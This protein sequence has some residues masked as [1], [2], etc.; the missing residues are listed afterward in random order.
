MQTLVE[1]ADALWKGEIGADARGIGLGNIGFRS[2][3]FEQVADG[4]WVLGMTVVVDT[5]QGLIIVDPGIRPGRR[6]RHE[7]VRTISDKPL[8]TAIYT[9]GH[10]DHIWGVDIFA[11]E[12]DARGWARP[13]V[14]AQENMLYRFKRYRKTARW[15]GLINTRQF[16]VSTYAESEV[17]PYP[18][19]YWEPDTT[20]RES[21]D[22][23]VGGVPAQ[24]RH[25][26]GETDDA[27]WVFFPNTGVLCTGDLFVWVVPNAGNPQKVQRYCAEWADALRAM[28]SCQPEILL[29]G[30]GLPIFGRERV[31][32]ALEETAEYLESIEDQT[33]AL[34]NAGATLDEVLQ[35]VRPPAHLVDRPFL[36]PVYDDP[37]FI[38]RNIWRLY[39]GWYDGQAAHLK[40]APERAQA[41]EVARLA[42]SPAALA[43]RAE[44]LAGEGDFRLACHLADWAHLAAPDDAAI[45][46][47]RGRIYVDRI[48][49]EQA[50]MAIGVFGFTAVEM[51]EMDNPT[52]VLVPRFWEDSP[53]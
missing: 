25:G 30:H 33:V 21:L 44:Q 50:T 45:R 41:A 18:S 53:H 31:R 7:R 37:E 42:G 5:P 51:G 11:E 36:R 47:I 15:N 8:H 6:Q 40:P 52:G 17:S 24:L 2:N 35:Q 23:S 19:E 27:T 1:Y 49:T 10:A 22:I 26:R 16:L 28:A 14:I 13:R 4:T 46:S 20:Y 9:H 48:K 3:G 38:V 12:A 32:Q 29:P 43:Q 34:M 39:G